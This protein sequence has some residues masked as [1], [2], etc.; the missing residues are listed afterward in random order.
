MT[1]QKKISLRVLDGQTEFAEDELQ[2]LGEFLNRF[3]KP[4]FYTALVGAALFFG[5]RFY[6]DAQLQK[7][8]SGAEQLL[9]V[10]DSLDELTKAIATAKK[11]VGDDK[12]K[13]DKIVSELEIKVREQVKTLGDRPVPYKKIAVVYGKVLENIKTDEG[14]AAAADPQLIQ[15]LLLSP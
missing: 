11:S 13:N 2:K 8:K 10:Q 9:I 7:Q 5:N 4:F 15:N 6:Q 14:T 1:E 12:A 3:S